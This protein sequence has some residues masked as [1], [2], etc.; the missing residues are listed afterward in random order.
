MAIA[1]GLSG[2]PAVLC[3]GCATMDYIFGVREF[4]SQPLKFRARDFKAVGGGNAATAAVAI[5]R[6]GGRAHLIAR[7]GDDLI[8][9]AI[10]GELDGYGVDCSLVHRF[11]GCASSIASILVDEQ[12]ERLIVSYFDPKI[13]HDPDWLPQIP[14]G[15]SAVLA[16]AH[17]PAGDLALFRRAA[18]TGIPTILDADMP[19]CAPELIRA[20]TVA[21]FSAPGLEG[22]TG[23]RGV[24]EGL[25]VAA[26]IGSGVMLATDGAEGVSWVE[27]GEFRHLAACPVQAVDTLG[28][29]DVFHGALALAVAEGQAMDRAVAFAN[30]AAAIKVTRFGGRAGSPTRA[31]VEQLLMTQAPI[32]SRVP[33]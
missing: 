10:L 22:A 33:G 32:T 9:E 16:D 21:A 30:A 20:S 13:P 6:L 25:R 24:M 11:P 28:A 19:A 18:A 23:T 27:R 1:G 5:A 15:V 2:C 29:G 7:L 26:R 14:A 8:G 3:M 17:W 4:P 12:G 31:E